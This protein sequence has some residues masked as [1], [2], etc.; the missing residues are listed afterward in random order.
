[1][2]RWS[3]KNIFQAVSHQQ[4]QDY[5][6]QLREAAEKSFGT[7][8]KL[9]ISIMNNTK[10]YTTYWDD[11]LQDNLDQINDAN[12]LLRTDD[13]ANV[14]T[15]LWG[16]AGYVEVTVKPVDE[17]QAPAYAFAHVEFKGNE[18]RQATFYIQPDGGEA[19][20]SLLAKNPRR[21]V[22]DGFTSNGSRSNALPSNFFL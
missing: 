5:T 3:L 13:V 4:F 21:I 10:V 6:T 17:T 18:P 20:A 2:T 16:K 15:A 19:K 9:D 7:P 14:S 11:G 12:T 1:M 22:G 8:C